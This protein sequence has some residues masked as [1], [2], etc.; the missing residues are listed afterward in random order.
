[1]GVFVFEDEI[2]TT[3]SPTRVFNSFVNN[4]VI[5]IKVAAEHV[6]SVETIEGDGGV[7][8]IRKITFHEGG[9]VK[10]KV[11]LID[12]VNLKYDDSVIEGDAVVG[13]IQ[14]ILNE[15]T[16]TATADG[17]SVVKAKCT[18]FTSDDAEVPAEI[19]AIG[20]EKRTGMF[21]ATEAYLLANP[22]AFV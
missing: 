20:K 11:E 22:D 19:L 12:S 5:F 8:T 14:K 2:T 1:M 7:G 9:H 3:V 13:S 4:H 10:I 16:I 6:K 18:F 15:N 21:K 17:G